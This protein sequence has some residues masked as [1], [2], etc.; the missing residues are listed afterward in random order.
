MS[1]TTSPQR[2]DR[3][4]ASARSMSSVAGRWALAAKNAAL[5]APALEPM[6]IRGR[7]P[8]ASSAGTSAASAPASY[9]P[10]APPPAR[11]SATLSCLGRPGT[12]AAYGFSLS[13]PMRRGRRDVP[14]CAAMPRG[15][16]PLGLESG[17]MRRLAHWVADRVVDHFE[18]VA[19]GPA[20]RAASPDELRCAL[21]GPVP[22]EPGDP[23]RAMET[24]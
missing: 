20:I 8:P 14:M 11:T 24:L 2:I 10:R 22:E 23:L 15:G 4:T 1:L 13:R 6:T 5:S 19:D 7:Q 21:G 17:E 3:Q 9:A 18:H 12:G 16:D